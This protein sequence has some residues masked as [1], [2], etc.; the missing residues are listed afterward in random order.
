MTHS[1]TQDRYIPDAQTV[2]AH[3]DEFRRHKCLGAP[4]TLQLRGLIVMT[5]TL[6]AMDPILVHKAR[7]AIG[8]LDVF[9]PDNDPDGFHDFGAVEIDDQKIWFKI[10]LYEAGSDKRYGAER[11]DNPVTTERVMTLMLPSDW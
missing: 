2:A 1:A 7:V 4:L 5:Q 11:P 3:N 8:R 6:A 10:N 9:E